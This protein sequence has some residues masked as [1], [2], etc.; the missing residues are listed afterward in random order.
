MRITSA[1]GMPLPVRFG[2]GYPTAFPQTESERSVIGL[3]ANAFRPTDQGG[4]RPTYWPTN[5]T[6]EKRAGSCRNESDRQRNQ[7]ACEE[8]QNTDPERFERR[9]HTKWSEIFSKT[10][11]K[12]FHWPSGKHLFLDLITTEWSQPR[13]AMRSYTNRPV[14]N[15]WTASV[16]SLFSTNMGLVRSINVERF[17]R[18][19][20]S[21]IIIRRL[22][23]IHLCPIIYWIVW[24]QRTIS[25]YS[26]QRLWKTMTGPILFSY[27]HFQPTLPPPKP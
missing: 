11:V 2:W 27:G 19:I 22:V 20:D 13:R 12:T 24:N 14:V 3:L 25:P 8:C 16:L 9:L 21:R 17:I 4:E 23:S 26:I 15:H 6:V 18:I 5:E 10:E 7:N 1:I